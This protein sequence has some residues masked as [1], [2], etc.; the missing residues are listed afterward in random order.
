MVSSFLAGCLIALAAIIYLS[1]GGVVGSL[2]FGIGLFTIAKFGLNLYTG[3]LCDLTIKEGK[4]A[5]ILLGNCLGTMFSGMVYNA[6][7]DKEV[8]ARANEIMDT[9]I[10]TSWISLL[11]Y[12][13]LCGVCIFLALRLGSDAAV[14]IG[15]MC[16]IL[17]GFAH[18]I[19][20]S[21][22]F[23]IA[24]RIDSSIFWWKNFAKVGVVAIGNF[25][26]GR[27]FS[28]CLRY[29]RS[30]DRQFIPTFNK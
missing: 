5:E 4:L 16:F 11:L 9:R 27:G 25:I 20:D 7:G 10:E 19:A 23:F 17:A 12:G 8:I 14:F 22:Y 6:F 29:I 1:V 21:A 3:K 13:I 28:R 18:S 15:V 2:L 30:G 26:G 24:G